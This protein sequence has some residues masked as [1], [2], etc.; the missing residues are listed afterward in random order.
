[1]KNT[2]TTINSSL[3]TV[4]KVYAPLDIVGNTFGRYFDYKRETAMIRHETK[5][6]KIQAKIMGQQIDAEL[7]KSLDINDK[8]FKKEMFRL[9]SIAKELKNGTKAKSKLLKQ[10]DK[11]IEMLGDKSLSVEEKKSIPI[12]IEQAN[13]LLANEG[14]QAIEKLNMM[15]HFDANTKLIGGE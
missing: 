5:K 4:S 12:L 3:P 11:Y 15:S 6:V 2:I 8:N 13:Q 7:Q 1:M 14:N 9:E 10:I